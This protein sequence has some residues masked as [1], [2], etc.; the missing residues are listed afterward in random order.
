M[1]GQVLSIT[2][3]AHRLYQMSLIVR[4]SWQTGL[5]PDEGSSALHNSYICKYRVRNEEN[6]TNSQ[7]NHAAMQV[8]A[9]GG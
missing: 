1:Q 3:P 2:T 4:T 9:Q 5:L 7:T 8:S 6:G